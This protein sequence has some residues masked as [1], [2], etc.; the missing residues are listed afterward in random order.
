M[1]ANAAA[2]TDLPKRAKDIKTFCATWG[3]GI[4]TFYAEVA[5][6]CLETIKVRGRRLV[7]AEQEERWRL[8]KEAAGRSAA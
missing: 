2:S 7:T 6:G 8:R 5:D 3:I 4:N 1:R